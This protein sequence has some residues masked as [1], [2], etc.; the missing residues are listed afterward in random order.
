MIVMN[1]PD[2]I[3]E[4]IPNVV[5][6]AKPQA[7]Q[8]PW[9]A[10]IVPF[11]LSTSIGVLC[12]RAAG[13]SLGLFLGGLLLNLLITG[14]IVAA[15]TT[16]LGR[17]LAMAG[18]VH[19]VA[20]VWFY[21]VI[22]ADFDLGIWAV[23]YLT[24][25]CT[26][27]AVGTFATLLNAFG[28]GPVGSGAVTAFLTIAWLTWPIWLSPA[29]HGSSGATIAHWLVPAHPVFAVNSVLGPKMGY[30]SEQGIIYN[31]TNLGDDIGY[32]LP[33]GVLACMGLHL[34]WAVVCFGII[35]L[36]ERIRRPRNGGRI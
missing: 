24:L 1:E 29:L 15:E 30:W 12:Y 31:F 25:A 33:D 22:H 7:A 36:I 28:I 8:N 35:W 6:S 16:W 20:G 13:V 34:G 19:G 27:V 32:S 4:S 26:V 9:L 10:M 17:F 23:S 5:H 14:P 3:V 11:V 21:A 2:Y 18:I